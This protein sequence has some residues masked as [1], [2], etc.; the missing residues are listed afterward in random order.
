MHHTL[1]HSLKKPLYRLT[2]DVAFT[3]PNG[4]LAKS[5]AVIATGGDLKNL[6]H[7]RDCVG[8]TRL[9]YQPIRRNPP[10]SSSSS[11]AYQRA[12]FYKKAT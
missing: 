9:V 12:A 2:L 11:L 5:P 1:H 6:A 4:R 7:E 3:F 8:A 10:E